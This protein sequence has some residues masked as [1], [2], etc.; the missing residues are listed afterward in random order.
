MNSK[1]YALIIGVLLAVSLITSVTA[2]AD[3]TKLKTM[4][5]QSAEAVYREK[6]GIAESVPLKPK[7]VESLME[8]QITDEDN[9]NSIVTISK[10]LIKPESKELIAEDLLDMKKEFVRRLAVKASL[11]VE[12]KE[13]ITEQ[14]SNYL[15]AKEDKSRIGFSLREYRIKDLFSKRITA[16][17]MIAEFLQK[18]A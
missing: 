11:S 16:K 15:V 18:Q 7:S 3:I 2:F 9:F 12:N 8:R 10:L 4:K 5:L 6:L 14:V 17:A 1:M 13:K